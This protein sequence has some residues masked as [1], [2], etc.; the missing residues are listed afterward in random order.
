[1][2]DKV[3]RFV[4]F[5]DYNIKVITVEYNHKVFTVHSLLVN[6]VELYSLNLGRGYEAWRIIGRFQ[7]K[8]TNAIRGHA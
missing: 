5:V 1:M 2:L 7:L 4:S 8:I 6:V 3:S